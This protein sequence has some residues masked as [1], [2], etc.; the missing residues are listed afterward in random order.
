MDGPEGQ[1]I[2]YH[3]A[4]NRRSEHWKVN[5]GKTRKARLPPGKSTDSLYEA[6]IELLR[7]VA[8]DSERQVRVLPNLVHVPDEVAEDFSFAIQWTK[9]L[10]RE[11][12]ITA[13]H[14]S[15]FE[16]I[17]AIFSRMDGDLRQYTLEAFRASPEWNDTRALAGRLLEALGEAGGPLDLSWM[18]YVGP[19]ETVT[20]GTE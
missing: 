2:V 1:L 13:A 18:S 15:K 20:G 11:R 17:D 3:S 7:L 19:R 5:N 10:L 12:R 4:G 14:V 9:R 16:E 6:M 8:A